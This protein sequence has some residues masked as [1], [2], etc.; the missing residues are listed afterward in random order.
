MK[1]LN[2][3]HIEPFKHFKVLSFKKH[4]INF[5]EVEGEKKGV[6]KKFFSRYLIQRS[7]DQSIDDF[8]FV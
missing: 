6:L 8:I 5:A 3:Y 4:I 7:I 2:W 1:L